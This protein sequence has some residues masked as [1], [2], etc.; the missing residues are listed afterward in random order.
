MSDGRSRARLVP[1]AGGA[2]L[3]VTTAGAGVPLVLC[4][5][6]PGLWDYL[7]PL[8]RLLPG[9]LRVHRYDQRGCGRSTGDGPYTVGQFV[10]DL[11]DVRQ[12]VDEP[13]WWVGGHSWGAEL[14]LRYALAY[15][16]RTR[17][18]VYLAGTG[19]GDGFRAAY[20]AEMRRRLGRDLPRWQY[21]HDK[22][23][24]TRAEEHEFCL[25]Q[26][27]PDY[28]PGPAA[29]GF[30]A[31]MWDDDLRMNLRCNRELAADRS[32]DE[33]E[34]AR[35]CAQLDVPVLIVHGAADPRPAWATDSLV[36][37]LPD[38]R[39]VVIEGAGHLPWA[40]QPSIVAGEIRDFILAGSRPRPR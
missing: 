4:H 11:D 26:W 23:D 6:G 29:A 22:P 32:R 15:P 28:A 13:S 20:R 39:R 21:L 34:L 1:V 33:A 27:R 9:E 38:V 3:R 24:R 12:V 25:L 2:L 19:I 5:G 30:A 35:C 14:A 18:L 40:E 7:G 16:A 17:G 36:S 10:A 8:A 37:A 31:A